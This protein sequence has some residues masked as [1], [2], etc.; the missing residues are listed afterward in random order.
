MHLDLTLVAVDDGHVLIDA[1]EAHEVH[2]VLHLHVQ[3]DLLKVAMI[4]DDYLEAHNHVLLVL[5]VHELKD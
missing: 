2:E 4:V 1:H 3:R 5:L